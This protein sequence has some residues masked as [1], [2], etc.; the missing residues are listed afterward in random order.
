MMRAS[1]PMYLTPQTAAATDRLWQGIRSA[2]AQHGLESPKTL[3]PNGIGYD[4]WTAPDLIFSQTCGMPYRTRLHGQVVLIGTPDHG[5]AGCP[6]GFYRS[7]VVKR[8][9][10]PRKS[11][12]NARVAYNGADSQSGFAALANSLG[13]DVSKTGRWIETGAHRNSA[14]AVA[15]GHA[16]IAA[17]DCVTWA[18]LQDDPEYVDE[19]S[20][21]FETDPTPG[22]PYICANSQDPK[23]VF[24]AVRTAI[25]SLSQADK[26]TLQ[27]YDLID[28]PASEYLRV[29]T[30]SPMVLSH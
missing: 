9:D 3:D 7:V 26:D 28:I 13:P 5:A 15:Q 12:D 6:K 21:L 27:L 22:L 2:M 14:I 30:P 8:R 20:V 29:P 11:T 25:V 4:Y 16:D 23:P 10:D 1:L 19:L 17:L 18:L 24:Q